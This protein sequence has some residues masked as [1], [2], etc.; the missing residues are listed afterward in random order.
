MIDEDLKKLQEEYPNA[1]WNLDYEAYE[2][3]EEDF[4]RAWNEDCAE[5]F[6]YCMNYEP[7][8]WPDWYE[9]NWDEYWPEQGDA[10]G[11]MMLN[12]L[13]YEKWNIVE[14]LDCGDSITREGIMETLFI[15]D[16]RKQMQWLLDHD[17]HRRDDALWDTW[18]KL[19]FE[20]DNPEG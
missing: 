6:D 19:C 14:V 5:Y 10:F 17:C 3:N 2:V 12:A 7:A 18:H 4:N 20:W 13:I 1:W 9:E 16:M 15:R 8:G 11:S